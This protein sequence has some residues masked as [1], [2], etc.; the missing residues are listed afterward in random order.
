MPPVATILLTVTAGILGMLWLTREDEFHEYR[1]KRFYWSLPLLIFV[2]SCFTR[3][4]FAFS[5]SA[6]HLAGAMMVLFMIWRDP[7]THYGSQVFLV[8]LFGNGQGGGSVVPTFNFA[9]K[10]IN[11]DELE[12]AEKEILQQLAKDPQN[13]DGNRMLAAIYQ[14]WKQPDK[15]IKR[16]DVAAQRPDIPESH[17]EFIKEAREQLLEQKEH[18]DKGTR[19]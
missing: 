17:A 7:L 16:L 11:D 19:R 3:V 13:F 18:L 9:Q 12:D 8:G 6:L 10:L 4:S 5:N 1:W 14:E 15:A 2:G